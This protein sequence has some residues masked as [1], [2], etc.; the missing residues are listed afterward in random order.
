M[1]GCVVL[2][3]IQALTDAID[4]H[5]RVMLVCGVAGRG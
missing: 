2:G 4:T 1:I 5:S 3:V